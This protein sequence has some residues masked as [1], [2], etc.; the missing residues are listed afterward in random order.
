MNFVVENNNQME[1][2]TEQDKII[3]KR[4]TLIQF[5]KNL[6]DLIAENLTLEDQ[7]LGCN[8]EFFCKK[9][10][11]IQLQKKNVCLFKCLYLIH[12]INVYCL[13]RQNYKNN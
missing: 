12:S 8:A 11:L 10:E 4:L 9:T 1:V 3:Q 5:K 6:K 7:K 2:W 13:F